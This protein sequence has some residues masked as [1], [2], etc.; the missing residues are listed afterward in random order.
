MT[1]AALTR[2]QAEDF[3]Y[4]ES[5]LLDTWR[6]EEWA[7]LFAEEGQYN[8]PS[9]DH[10]ADAPDGSL[11]LISDNRA[12]IDERVR[13]LLGATAWAENPR[14]RTRHLVTNVRV[15]ATSEGRTSVHANFVVYRFRHGH[16]HQYVGQYKYQLDVSQGE[17][18]RIASKTVILDLES[19]SDVGK[20]SIIL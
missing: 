18:P 10:P 7:E 20:V 5:D 13:Q 2:D 17:R 14:S 3:I 15:G 4:H 6:L 9:P 16:V 11:F 19:L 8:V 1:S 12:R